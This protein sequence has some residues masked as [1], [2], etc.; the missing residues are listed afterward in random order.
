MFTVDVKGREGKKDSCVPV[1]VQ[2]KWEAVYMLEQRDLALINQACS[3]GRN[4]EVHATPAHGQGETKGGKEDETEGLI[5]RKGTD[6]GWR[7]RKHSC[8]SALD[9]MERRD[10]RRRGDGG[11]EEGERCEGR[12]LQTIPSAQLSWSCLTA[13]APASRTHTHAHAHRHAHRH[14]QANQDFSNPI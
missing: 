10:Q 3:Q 8:T 1:V 12:S 9:V 14:T 13:V 4:A 2:F 5:S 11:K 6:E 7:W